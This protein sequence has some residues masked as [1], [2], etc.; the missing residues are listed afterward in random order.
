MKQFYLGFFTGSLLAG[1]YIRCIDDCCYRNH[2]YSKAIKSKSG[3]LPYVR[4][5]KSIHG[6]A[7]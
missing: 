4:N 2:C 7:R 5:R 3:R 1:I 6:S